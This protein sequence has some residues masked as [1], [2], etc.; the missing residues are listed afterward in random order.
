MNS[1]DNN[2]FLSFII[3]KSYFY[4][5]IIT[6]YILTIP[7]ALTSLLLYYIAPDPVAKKIY[8]SI[9]TFL[10]AYFF[11]VLVPLQYV[12]LKYNFFHNLLDKKN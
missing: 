10:G 5:V 8:I 3:R 9:F 6:L 1:T 7:A 2:R 4:K 11:L 12:E